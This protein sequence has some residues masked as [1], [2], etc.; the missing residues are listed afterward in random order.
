MHI[1][2][3]SL[4]SRPISSFY[5]FVDI[6]IHSLRPVRPRSG[7]RCQP[8]TTAKAL[9][10]T[11]PRA[12]TTVQGRKRHRGGDGG[13]CPRATPTPCAAF[14]G[15]ARN[16]PWAGWNRVES[17]QCAARMG[18]AWAECGRRQRDRATAGIVSCSRSTAFAHSRADADPE[19]GHAA[20]VAAAPRRPPP[21]HHGG[22][23][24]NGGGS[25]PGPSRSCPGLDAA[26][27]RLGRRLLPHAP[28]R[29]G[30]EALY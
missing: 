19:T 26:L 3:V 15:V 9:M 17:G 20:P 30:A 1:G 14:I 16:A 29:D 25:R 18:V 27:G 6:L 10:A 5:T 22:A 21:T 24:P 12:V 7:S 23:G 11:P 28:F 2:T 13:C 4:N 8:T